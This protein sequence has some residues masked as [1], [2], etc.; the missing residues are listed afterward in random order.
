MIFS[1]V[2][3]QIIEMIK[4]KYSKKLVTSLKLEKEN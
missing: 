2:K 3:F 4:L 1:K